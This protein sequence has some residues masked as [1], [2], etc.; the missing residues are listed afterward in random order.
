M[1]D[2]AVRK[3]VQ[4]LERGRNEARFEGNYVAGAQDLDSTMAAGA[5]RRSA[6]RAVP[7]SGGVGTGGQ[8]GSRSP[9]CQYGNAKAR[10]ELRRAQ[11]VCPA[12]RV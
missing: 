7:W 11:P 8:H 4:V 10:K 3:L 9:E 2:V 12:H 5:K 1:S 6:P